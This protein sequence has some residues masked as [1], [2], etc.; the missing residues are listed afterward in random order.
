MWMNIKRDRFDH[1][2]KYLPNFSY[3]AYISWIK[4]LFKINSLLLTHLMLLC[5]KHGSQ[6]HILTLNCDE[7]NLP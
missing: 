3:E 4:S 6:K 5:D 2:A 1:E 7:F